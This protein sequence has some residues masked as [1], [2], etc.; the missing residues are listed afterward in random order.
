MSAV[1]V[2]WKHHGKKKKLLIFSK[3]SFSQCFL[4]VFKK[5]KL[6]SIFIKFEIVVCKLFQFGSLEEV[7]FFFFFFFFWG[8]GGGEER[9]VKA[10]LGRLLKTSQE[11]ETILVTWIL[12][13][14]CNELPFPK[15]DQINKKPRVMCHLKML[16][17]WTSPKFLPKMLKALRQSSD[18]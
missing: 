8:G 13:F 12:S 3:F 10:T 15:T 7:F 16:S 14:S 2:F 18:L 17:M 9:M 11:K 4:T 1:Q 5:K 6:L